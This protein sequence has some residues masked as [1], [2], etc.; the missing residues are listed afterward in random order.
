MS[1]DC[2]QKYP[3]IDC[4]SEEEVS[5]F[6]SDRTLHIDDPEGDVTVITLGLPDGSWNVAASAGRYSVM[7]SC[8]KTG[9][10]GSYVKVTDELY[11]DDGEEEE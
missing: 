1:A 11:V 2:K 5:L 8:I 9:P 7:I 4:I 3:V 10:E 6:V